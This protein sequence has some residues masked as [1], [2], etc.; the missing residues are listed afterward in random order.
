M[1]L[2]PYNSS[3]NHKDYLKLIF[4]QTA[5]VWFVV[6][7][8]LFPVTSDLFFFFLPEKTGH[9]IFMDLFTRFPELIGAISSHICCLFS[10][11]CYL[12]IKFTLQYM[13]S[14]II[15]FLPH[16]Q[17]LFP[18]INSRITSSVI[19][20]LPKKQTNNT[21][22]G[23]FRTKCRKCLNNFFS[24]NVLQDSLHKSLS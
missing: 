18:H 20:P 12:Q 19:F 16:V 14:L 24:T 10:V 21:L 9:H 22:H 13:L 7:I 2:L 17:S 4:S 6:I 5:N 11:C 1:S 8:I 23:G 15:F 3:S